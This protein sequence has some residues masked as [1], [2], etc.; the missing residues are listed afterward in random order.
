MATPL[1]PFRAAYR[2]VLE[3]EEA[4]R[5]F[6]LAALVKHYTNVVDSLTTKGDLTYI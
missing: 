1:V 5:E 4:K 3:L 6:F 2:A